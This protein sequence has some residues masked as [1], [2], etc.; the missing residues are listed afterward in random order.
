MITD[1]ADFE[2]SRMCRGRRRRRAVC[3]RWCWRLGRSKSIRVGVYNVY[4]LVRW[5]RVGN[6]AVLESD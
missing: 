1:R 5:T 2:L 4:E 3:G 6:K